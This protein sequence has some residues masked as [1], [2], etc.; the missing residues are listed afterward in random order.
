MNS[1]KEKN[2]WILGYTIYPVRKI[3]DSDKVANAKSQLISLKDSIEMIEE[4]AEKTKIE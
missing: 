2:L 4:R 1:T 3:L